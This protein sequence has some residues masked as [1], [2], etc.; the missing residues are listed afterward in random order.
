[1]TVPVTARKPPRGCLQAWGARAAA[2][3]AACSI[4]HP[5]A[6]CLDGT[7]SMRGESQL[8]L[9]RTWRQ[10][11][12]Q[13]ALANGRAKRTGRKEKGP[14]PCIPCQPQKHRW[15]LLQPLQWV[16]PSALQTTG[17]GVEPCPKTQALHRAQGRGTGMGTVERDISALR[18]TLQEP[19]AKGQ[20]Q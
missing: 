3:L 1:M 17:R 19:G 12:T 14:R 16:L 6:C 2:S 11:F 13:A 8:P 4:W 7:D 18:R 20:N 15:A 5:L 9:S 10:R